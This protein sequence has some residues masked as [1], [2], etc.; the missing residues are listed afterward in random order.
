M[1][2]INTK[3]ERR[4][5]WDKPFAESWDDEKLAQTLELPV[6]AA[7]DAGKFPASLSLEGIVQNDA[8][9]VHYEPGDIVARE[10]DYGS[11][12]FVIVSGEISV[13]LPPGLPASL[14]GRAESTG[15]ESWWSAL[16]RIFNRSRY[17]ETRHYAKENWDI[18]GGLRVKQGVT[19]V[20]LDNYRE[21]L[22][23]CQ[24]LPIGQGELVGEVAA[25][26]RSP[27]TASMVVTQPSELLEIRWQGFRDLRKYDEGFRMRVDGIY[28][29]RN[30]VSYLKASPF[31]CSFGRQC[32]RANC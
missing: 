31:F 20:L 27:R 14:L 15:P 17:R 10:D 32:H 5:R 26:T 24:L 16:K 29:E 6:F 19:R 2:P 25:L 1:E 22:A 23:E 7:M 9:L 18:K 28:R 13:V 8:R 4:K 21:V 30:R 12:A 3:I 11:S